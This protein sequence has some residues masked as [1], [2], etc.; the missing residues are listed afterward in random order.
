MPE[1]VTL[2]TAVTKPSRT[3]IE[4]ER[5]TIDIKS[6]SVFIQWLADNG[7]AGSASYPTPAPVDAQGNNL[8]PSGATLINA[9]NNANLSTKSLVKRIYERLLTDRHFGAGTITGTP[10]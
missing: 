1:R 3:A 9:L 6:K 10:D 4:L 8:Q 5:V 2:T 7:D